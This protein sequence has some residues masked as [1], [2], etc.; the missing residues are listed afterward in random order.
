MCSCLTFSDCSFPESGEFLSCVCKNIGSQAQY[1]GY[2]KNLLLGLLGLLGPQKSVRTHICDL[3]LIVSTCILS[4]LC[5]IH[6]H[7]QNLCHHQPHTS[8]NTATLDLSPLFAGL[9]T[10]PWESLA[11]KIWVLVKFRKSLS[12]NV[13]ARTSWSPYQAHGPILEGKSYSALTQET[14]SGVKGPECLFLG[15]QL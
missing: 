12:L 13:F 2:W 5:L 6:G 9:N 14:R 3:A 10:F 15:P 8:P 7:S 4:L 1:L 11:E